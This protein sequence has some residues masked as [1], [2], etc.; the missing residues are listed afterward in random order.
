MKKLFSIFFVLALLWSGNVWAQENENE[1]SR[2]PQD[3][4]FTEASNMEEFSKDDF[5]TL[6]PL[7][8]SPAAGQYKNIYTGIQ[9][10]K[11]VQNGTDGFTISLRSTTLTSGKDRAIL[12]TAKVTTGSNTK[13]AGTQRVYESEDCTDNASTFLI[14]NDNRYYYNSPDGNIIF[15][16]KSVN[17]DGYPVYNVSISG[18]YAGASL[19]N[20]GC[21]WYI[22]S[23]NADLPVKAFASDGSTPIT[24]TDYYKLTVVSESA[25]KGSVSGDGSASGGQY[26][27]AGSSHSNLTATPSSASYAFSKWQKNGADFSGNTANPLSITLNSNDTYTAIFNAV[28]TT[29]TISTAASPVNYGSASGGGTYAE[30]TS[31]TLSATPAS[32]AYGFVKWQKNGADFAGN[33][34]NPIT[35]TVTAAAT[36][37]AV[38]EHLPQGVITVTANPTYGTA[39]GSGSYERGTNVN[40]SATPNSG[41]RFAQWDDGD[42]NNPRTITVTGDKT[43]TAQFYDLNQPLLASFSWEDDDIVVQNFGDGDSYCNSFYKPYGK[44]FRNLFAKTNS[45]SSKNFFH[46]CIQTAQTQS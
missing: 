12:A 1:N 44:Y 42:T 38:F 20:G 34:V 15:T 41:Y 36:Y 4:D 29:C 10:C 14:D 33:T 25:S 22:F 23:Y 13:I 28:S 30:N 9:Y 27:A 24:L 17:S 2:F 11:C 32:L 6:S 21:N 19:S 26:Y 43:Y 39:T 18:M 37:T 45:R 3:Q 16:W 7:R 31:A 40:I 35:V 46:L 8:R 5:S